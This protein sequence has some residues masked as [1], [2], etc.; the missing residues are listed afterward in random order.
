[1]SARSAGL[2]TIEAAMRSA[3][4]LYKE[5]EALLFECYES[6]FLGVSLIQVLLQRT[7]NLSAIVGRISFELILD[8]HGRHGAYAWSVSHW[9]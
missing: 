3:D 6:L 1:M 4:A 2:E 9:M 5:G 7:E 8:L